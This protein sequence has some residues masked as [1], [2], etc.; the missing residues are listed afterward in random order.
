VPEKSRTGVV[1]VI[2]LLVLAV[3]AVVAAAGVSTYRHFIRE[4]TLAQMGIQD[5]SYA[6]WSEDPAATLLA[7]VVTFNINRT[8]S[9][10]EERKVRFCARKEPGT[11][12]N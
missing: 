1:V 8:N 4:V 7:H 9:S 3:I 6:T 10:N 5:K 11:T 2:C 12:D